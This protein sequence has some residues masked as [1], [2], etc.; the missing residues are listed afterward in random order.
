MDGFNNNDDIVVMAATNRKD[1]LDQAILRPGRFDRII[2]I[3][4]PDK[5]SR[6][7]ILEYYLSSKNTQ[8]TPPLDISAIAEMTDGLSGAQLK[9]LINE[10]T[11]MS[12]KKNDT[13]LR[14]EYIFDSFEKSIVGLIKT[15]TSSYQSTRE[16]VAFHESGHLLLVLQFA[17]Y[18]NFQ[19]ASIKPTYEGAGGYTLFTENPE[20]REGGLYTKD[21]LKKRLI[22]T[23]GGKAAETIFYGEDFVSV[24]AYQDLKQANDLAKRMIGNFGMG[25]ELQVFFNE[26]ISDGSNPFLGRSLSNGDKYSEYTRYIMD[27][28]SLDLVNEA[29]NEAKR[30]ILE[31]RKNLIYF[32]EFLQKNTIL[33]KS[34]IT[35]F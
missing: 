32:A 23:M 20:I 33:Y 12:V 35:R 4:L 2:R 3:P 1:V 15:N 24:G 28:E 26:E 34:N 10:A 31:N 6:E 29:F 5:Q 27:K 7:K 8:K 21:I 25:E 16:R 13:V 22:I 19:K 14:E 17:E 18:F 9:N 11:I 30:I